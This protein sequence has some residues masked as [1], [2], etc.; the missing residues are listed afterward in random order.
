MGFFL[1]MFHPTSNPD[2][3]IPIVF[4]LFVGESLHIT[5]VGLKTYLVGPIYNCRALVNHLGVAEYQSNLRGFREDQSAHMYNRHA[6][7]ILL[8]GFENA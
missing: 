8:H 7:K 4:V 2:Q 1:G 6:P 5:M 3:N